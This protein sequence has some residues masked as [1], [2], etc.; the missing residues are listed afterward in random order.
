MV[1]SLSSR[2]LS[3]PIPCGECLLFEMLSILMSWAGLHPSFLGSHN[4]NKN[5]PLGARRVHPLLGGVPLQRRALSEGSRRHA[6]VIFHHHDLSEPGV[7]SLFTILCFLFLGP[8]LPQ[9]KVSVSVS[10]SP[11]TW[12]SFHELFPGY[13]IPWP[14][15]PSPQTPLFSHQGYLY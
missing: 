2:L 1:A 10:P 7:L 4:R 8:L 3:Y 14:L 6:E 5:Y 13:G 11:I 12:P 15:L 9:F